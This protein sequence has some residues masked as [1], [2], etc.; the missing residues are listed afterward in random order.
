MKTTEHNR[1]IRKL[2]AEDDESLLKLCHALADLRSA[3][4]R[5]DDA[6]LDSMGWADLGRD[7]RKAEE[8]VKDATD[9]CIRSIA[10]VLD[11]RDRHDLWLRSDW[12]R[13]EAL[14]AI[15]ASPGENSSE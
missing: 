4:M 2:L 3:R 10:K 8:A 7:I 13:P 9:E 1:T 11:K 15:G 12:D 14:T 5:I 6:A